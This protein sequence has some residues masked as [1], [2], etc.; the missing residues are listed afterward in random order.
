LNSF[1]PIPSSANGGLNSFR[2]GCILPMLFVPHLTRNKTEI[3]VSVVSNMS[4]MG[5]A[6]TLAILTGSVSAYAQSTGTAAKHE[7]EHGA[8][9]ASAN[10][11]V[12]SSEDGPYVQDRLPDGTPTGPLDPDRG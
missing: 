2:M 10:Q 12:R 3:T 4:K 1:E 6:L 5:M 8:A 7:Q 11:K 9:S